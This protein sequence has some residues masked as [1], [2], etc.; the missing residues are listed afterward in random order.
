MLGTFSSLGLTIQGLFCELGP[1]A[2]R[3]VLSR[4]LEMD[5]AS[6]RR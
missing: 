5:R 1:N 6:S 2:F 3:K 4:P